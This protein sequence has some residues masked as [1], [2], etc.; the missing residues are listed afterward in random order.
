[1][2][3]LTQ[4]YLKSVLD[5]DPESGLFKWKRHSGRTKSTYV[6]SVT[7][8][9]YIYIKID[10]TGYMAHR[11]AW[12]WVFGEFPP[13]QIDHINGKK[14]DNRIE[15]LREATNTENV[16]GGK[17]RS[18]NTTGYKGVFLESRTG[19][20]RAR[21]TINS[22]NINL[23]FY[24]SAEEAAEARQKAAKLCFGQFYNPENE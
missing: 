5:Y 9:G 8:K 17:M 22:K 4:A 19:R 21:I 11:L 24:A 23:G 10:R 1:M 18:N 6:G 3:D 20:Y 7:S 16:R 15:N 12:L 13:D 2:T 14:D